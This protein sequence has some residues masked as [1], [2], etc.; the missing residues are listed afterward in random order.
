MRF[1]ILVFLNL[2]IGT[3]IFADI[4]RPPFRSG[5][6]HR[7]L[8]FEGVAQY[9]EYEFFLRFVEIQ[10]NG[11]P[12]RAITQWIPN[13]EPLALETTNQVEQLEIL[14]FSKEEGTRLRENH[15][16]IYPDLLNKALVTPL[17]SYQPT[18]FVIGNAI[19]ED[20]AKVYK[21]SLSI[22]DGK[23]TVTPVETPPTDTPDSLNSPT[24]DSIYSPIVPRWVIG[25]LV[26][27][28]LVLFGVWVGRKSKSLPQ[29]AVNPCSPV[30]PK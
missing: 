23:L 25:S 30:E 1:S 15:L 20:A 28:A 3:V 26:A 13:N 6:L 17:K 24:S 22:T 19:P 29:Q 7:N 16:H 21:Y 5:I 10:T 8:S 4:P 27:V 11:Q 18:K 14:A 12:N 2:L 9:P